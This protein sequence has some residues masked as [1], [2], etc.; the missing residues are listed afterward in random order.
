[1]AV[2]ATT[3]AANQ[4]VAGGCEMYDLNSIAKTEAACLPETAYSDRDWRVSGACDLTGPEGASA[5][6]AEQPAM[7]EAHVETETEQK[8]ALCP[9]LPFR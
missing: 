7:P 6:T 5:H 4:Q 3:C 9:L 2:T 8:A 1:M